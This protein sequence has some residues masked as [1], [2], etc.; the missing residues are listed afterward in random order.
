MAHTALCLRVEPSM[1]S[2]LG[3]AFWASVCVCWY[4]CGGALLCPGTS[5]GPGGGA[6]SCS[7][8]ERHPWRSRTRW[9][10]TGEHLALMGGRRL[11][12]QGGGVR[13]DP[14]GRC[15][16]RVSLRSA[17]KGPPIQRGL[18]NVAR[19]RG[20]Y[21]M[22]SRCPPAAGRYP[23]EAYHTHI[24]YQIAFAKRPCSGCYVITTAS[25]HSGK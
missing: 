23:G 7:L 25:G 19:D 13:F 14:L 21:P 1:F 16:P 17:A 5:L 20:A 22:T 18:A 4:S 15:E 12:H 11:G 2:L 8:D 24:N 6:I 3:S 10:T 9:G